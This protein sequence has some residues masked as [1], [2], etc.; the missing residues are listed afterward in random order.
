MRHG[1]AHLLLFAS[2]VAAVPAMAE[3]RIGLS[4][5]LDETAPVLAA[6]MQAGARD[7]AATLGAELL[8]EDDACTA[9]GG[10]R[11]ARVFVEAG[12][13]AVVGY[14][15]TAAIEAALPILTEAD[16]PVM[17]TGIRTDSLTDRRERTGWQ[18]FRLGPRADGERDAAARYVVDNWRE[19]PFAIVDDGTI[20]GRELAE[21]VRGAA[22]QSGLAPVFVDTFR[23]QLDNQIGLVGRLRRSGATHVFAGGDREDIAIMARDAAGLDYPLEIVGGEALRAAPGEVPLADGIGMVAATLWTEEDQPGAEIPVERLGYFAPTKAAV[24]IAVDAIVNGE[25]A[26]LAETIATGRF[27]TAI[28]IVTFDA[29]GDMDGDLYRIYRSRDGNFIVT[30]D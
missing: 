18:V 30:E 10:A 4:V 8:V 22:E 12:V 17:A 21:A 26:N 19:V 11:A 28:G 27:E 13:D 25:N 5:P 9:E 16:I 23:P 15:C 2:L 7:A 24:E 1:P 6:Q 14:L 3:G 20:Y 29:R